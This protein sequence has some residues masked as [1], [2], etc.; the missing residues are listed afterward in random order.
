MNTIIKIKHLFVEN[1]CI[2]NYDYLLKRKKNKL[3]SEMSLYDKW[4]NK[5]QTSDW[6][7]ETSVHLYSSSE[8]FT[9]IYS[10]NTETSTFAFNMWLLLIHNY[11]VYPFYKLPSSTTYIYMQIKMIEQLINFILIHF[12]L[13]QLAL[14]FC[15]SWMF[16]SNWFHHIFGTT[17]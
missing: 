1:I 10:T 8:K 11:L 15:F 5:R 12:T 13:S 2:G 4:W 3:F 7:W 9:I 16:H 6:F 14:C 17:I